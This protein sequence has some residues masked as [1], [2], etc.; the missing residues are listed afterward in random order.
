MAESE[1][2]H[3]LDVQKK[4]KQKPGKTIITKNINIKC[5]TVTNRHTRKSQCSMLF[6]AEAS[7]SPKVPVFGS[8]CYSLVRHLTL[9]GCQFTVFCTFSSVGDWGGRIW[10]SEYYLWW[11]VLEFGSSLCQ[12]CAVSSSLVAFPSLKP[13]TTIGYYH[14]L[15]ILLHFHRR[16][17]WLAAVNH[18]S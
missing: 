16:G 2:L 17:L 4:T 5:L 11:R 8:L 18:R 10:I 6:W 3:N 9:E 7:S 14:N 12:S 1:K 13:M 15:G